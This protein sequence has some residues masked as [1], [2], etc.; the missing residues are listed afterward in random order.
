M[1]KFPCCL[2]VWLCAALPAAP[3]T[4][5][6]A[7]TT[8]CFNAGGPKLSMQSGMVRDGL[9]LLLRVPGLRGDDLLRAARKYVNSESA[10]KAPQGY[11]DTRAALKHCSA[12]LLHKDGPPRERVVLLLHGGAYILKLSNIYRGMAVRYSRMAGDADVFSPDYRLAPE[13]VFPAAL[14]DA[15]DAWNWLLARGYKPQNIL[16][17]GD[18]AGG[19]LALALTLKLRD[20]GRALPRALICMSPWTDMTGSGQSHF[21]NAGIDPIFGNNPEYMPPKDGVPPKTLPFI[22]SYVGRADPKNSY[23]SPAFASYTHFPPMLIQVGTDEILESDAELVYKQALQAGVDATLTRYY[24]LFHVFQ[25]FGDIL[26]EGK[27]A[28]EEAAAFIRAK[29]LAPPAAHAPGNKGGQSAQPQKT[30]P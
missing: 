30:G 25:I 28:W 14:E 12:E 21:K 8:R 1:K 10:W 11:T 23:L 18:S 6:A 4:A 19:N 5:S 2:L 7:D 13:H 24:G 16:V 3:S 22:L 15:L 27:H 20:M 9:R 29:F 26:P 17:A